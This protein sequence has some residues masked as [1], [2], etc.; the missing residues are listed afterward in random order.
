MKILYT[1]GQ[2]LFLGLILGL[3]GYSF[4]GLAEENAN[5]VAKE[6]AACIREGGSYFQHPKRSSLNGCI[7]GE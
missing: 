1:I 3:M 5:I 4:A 6:K 2:V 7:F